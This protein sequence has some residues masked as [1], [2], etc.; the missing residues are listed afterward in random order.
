MNCIKY[1]TLPHSPV[2]KINN[3]DRIENIGS[4]R[5][6]WGPRHCSFYAFDMYINH[7]IIQKLGRVPVVPTVA[8]DHSTTTHHNFLWTSKQ[9]L[10]AQNPSCKKV[11]PLTGGVSCETRNEKT[12][13]LFRR[14]DIY[15]ILWGTE[16]LTA[17]LLAILGG[18]KGPKEVDLID[19]NE[20][21]FVKEAV[22]F[23]PCVFFRW[24]IIIVT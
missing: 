10:V 13:Y 6:L 12:D 18:N 19:G 5:F 17:V 20:S 22:T 16:V 9:L 15:R 24:K 1:S 8:L 21:G 7:L 2:V 14:N 4:Q 23:I 11:Y 3:K